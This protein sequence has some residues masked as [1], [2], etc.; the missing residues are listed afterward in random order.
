[1]EELFHSLRD[2]NAD[3]ETRVVIISGSRLPLLCRGRP[4]LGG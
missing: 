1:M 3:P 2:A 4:Q